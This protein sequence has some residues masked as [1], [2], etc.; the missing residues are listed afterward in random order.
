VKALEGYAAVVLAAGGSKRFGTNKLLLEI[1]GQAVLGHVL[2]AVL[3][4]GVEEIIVV[5]GPYREQIGSFLSGPYGEQIR[6]GKLRVV[7]N[8]DHEHGMAASLRIGA[9]SLTKSP[10]RGVFVVL[11]DHPRLL[12]QTLVRLAVEHRAITQKDEFAPVAHPRYNGKKGHPILLDGALIGE[13]IRLSNS[14]QIR[15]LTRR[16]RAEELIVDIPTRDIIDDLDD[17]ADLKKFQGINRPAKP[18][19]PFIS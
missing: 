12:P 5:T 6:A 10:L 13:A 18:I 1:N 4:S 11:A 8:P 7:Y 16:Y 15:Y 17:H 2:D 9:E 3:Q 19:L 14:D